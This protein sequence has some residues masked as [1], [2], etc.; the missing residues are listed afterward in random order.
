[1]TSITVWSL[2][3]YF[4][5]L[6]VAWNFFEKDTL[7]Q[8]FSCEVCEISKNAFFYRAS[9]VAASV[10]WTFKW[11]TVYRGLPSNFC[12]W[13]QWFLSKY[14]LCWYDFLFRIGTMWRNQRSGLVIRKLK[15]VKDATLILHL[16]HSG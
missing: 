4:F 12:P 6:Q 11:R 16:E 9:P 2:W 7:A 14:L 15:T 1:M 5:P 10:N 13:W 3:K 8:V